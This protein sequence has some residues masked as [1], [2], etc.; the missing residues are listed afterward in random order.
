[1]KGDGENLQTSKTGHK[2]VKGGGA[3]LEEM[4][5]GDRE[6]AEEL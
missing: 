3:E 1:M 4:E 2:E 5:D 6:R